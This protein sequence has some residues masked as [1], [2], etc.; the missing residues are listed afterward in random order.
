MDTIET[1]K[2]MMALMLIYGDNRVKAN[3]FPN[4][5]DDSVVDDD[6]DDYDYDFND[7]GV[8]SQQRHNVA[9]TGF[10][11]QLLPSKAYCDVPL[12]DKKNTS[13]CEY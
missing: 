13:Y 12:F 1:D 11:H 10:Q 9:Y 6:D 7:D 2:V 5:K 8:L 4:E 3:N